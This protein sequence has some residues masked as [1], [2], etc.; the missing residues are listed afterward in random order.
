MS[1]GGKVV[2]VTGAAGYIASWTVKLLLQR[3][4]T[5]RGT[6]RDPADRK[7]IEHLLKLDRAEERLKL[8]RADLL[9]EGSF[10]SM[11]DGC[12][13]VFHMASPV[14]FQDIKDPKVELID[15]AVKG[16]LNVLK[17]CAK[18][19]SVRRVVL[20]SSTAAVAYTGQPINADI[21]VDETWF[22]VPSVC[23]KLETLAEKAAWKFAE[24]NGLDLVTTN[25]G[26]IFGP[27]LQPTINFSVGIILDLFKGPTY[28]NGYVPN[29]DVRDV[30]NAHIQAF[31][32]ASACGRYCLV[33][34]SPH[35]SDIINILRESFPNLKL[36]EKCVDVEHDEL[37]PAINMS[38]EKARGLG[39]E[40]TPLEVSL[41]DTVERLK[42][43]NYIS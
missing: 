38:K 29:V 42:E 7:K 20:T 2:C 25:A 37:W 17:A 33:D 4:Y 31:E 9:E 15:P 35:F 14:K 5:V 18:A 22:S 24:E 28:P 3:G 32:I 12:D 21:L 16:T 23:E 27:P 39:I 6:L 34:S 10:D 13:G 40:F 30:A 11:V 8:F 26:Y 19:K 43:M 1:G 36:A 41:K